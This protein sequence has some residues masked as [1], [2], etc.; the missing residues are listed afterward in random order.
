[1]TNLVINLFHQLDRVMKFYYLHIWSVLD[2]DYE[3]TEYID[4]EV[5]PPKIG[6]VALE[7]DQWPADSLFQI[8]PLFFCNNDL[9]EGLDDLYSECLE[10]K[11]VT[12]IIKGQNFEALNPDAKLPNCYWRI[13]FKGVPLKDHFSLWKDLYFIVSEEALNHLRECGVLNAEAD[14]IDVDVEEY[15]SSARKDFWMSLPPK[16]V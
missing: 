7:I 2:F 15:F 4:R 6:N 3:K 9:K 16:A 11:K 8:W 5:H 13:K 1:M 10:F 14:L 12:Q